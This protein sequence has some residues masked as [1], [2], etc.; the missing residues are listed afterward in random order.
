MCNA[1]TLAC[2]LC[3]ITNMIRGGSVRRT[4]ENETDISVSFDNRLDKLMLAYLAS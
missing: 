4:L 1:N 2:K 3:L